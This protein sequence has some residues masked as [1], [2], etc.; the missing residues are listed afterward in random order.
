MHLLT[1]CESIY[2]QL[3]D[4]AILTKVLARMCYLIR[5]FYSLFLGHLIWMWGKN[6][7]VEGKETMLHIHISE[8]NVWLRKECISPFVLFFRGFWKSKNGHQ[9][10]SLPFCL[11]LYLHFFKE[12]MQWSWFTVNFI[13][14]R[15]MR[16]CCKL[17]LTFNGIDQNRK[18]N[19]FHMWLT[20]YIPNNNILYN[21]KY[22]PLDM[23]T[24]A[25]K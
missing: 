19:F 5:L 24:T 3:H 2:E 6:R 8:Q 21:F 15:R 20:Y 25:N 11:G 16:T 14:K 10:A 7:A 1:G 23:S 12:C 4:N 22:P 17:L 9:I 18:Y 13:N